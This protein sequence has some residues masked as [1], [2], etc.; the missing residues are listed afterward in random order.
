MFSRTTSR[1]SSK[2]S[3]AIIGTSHSVTEEI[4]RIPPKI[5]AAVSATIIRPIVMRKP[6][7]LVPETS[8]L[9][10]FAAA[11]TTAFV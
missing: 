2:Y 8:M 4:A 1:P 5:I 6:I 3:T 10:E 7:E 9:N 11:S